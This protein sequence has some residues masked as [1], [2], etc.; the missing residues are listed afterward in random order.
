MH[1][2]QPGRTVIIS[3]VHGCLDELENLLSKVN[4]IPEKDSLTLLGDIINRGPYSRETF[5]RIQELGATSILGNHEWHLL[6]SQRSYEKS[7]KFR[8]LHTEFGDHFRIFLDEIAKWPAF[9]ETNDYILVHAGLVPGIPPGQTDPRILTSIRTWDGKG[10]DLNDPSNP[11]WFELYKGN[12][13][14]V[15]GHWAALEGIA[16]DKYIG[17]DTGCVYGKRLTALLL[18][19]KE[20]VSVPAR[21]VYCPI[22]IE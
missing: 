17:I 9:I 3:D 18:P 7:R 1:L 21:K 12:K 5:L 22:D 8:K 14:V 19:E 10:E 15:F 2:I 20:L 13:S 11:P 16:A 4:F 6:K